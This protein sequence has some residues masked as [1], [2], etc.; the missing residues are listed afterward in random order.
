MNDSF[1]SDLEFCTARRTNEIGIYACKEIDEAFDFI[2]KTDLDQKA[3]RIDVVVLIRRIIIAAVLK[4][5]R[6]LGPKVAAGVCHEIIR[7]ANSM[8]QSYQN[9]GGPDER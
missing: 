2:V 9:Y 6:E 7:L 8:L 3:Q 4:T 5:D 1:S